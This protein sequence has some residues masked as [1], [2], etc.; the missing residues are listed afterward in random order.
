MKAT[1]PASQENADD[2]TCPPGSSRTW[3]LNKISCGLFCPLVTLGM[4]RGRGQ[5]AL[6]HWTSRK[7][8]PRKQSQERRDPA[9]SG[10]SALA[11]RGPAGT[12]G[13]ST[14]RESPRNADT[15][16][17][18]VGT[19]GT[20]PLVVGDR[21]VGPNPGNLHCSTHKTPGLP[22]QVAERG[23]AAE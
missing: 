10:A 3:Q 13:S 21:G 7:A 23:L 8:P 4:A 15:G 12:Y 5:L 2:L 20:W 22:V 11:L 1:C 18:A 16:Q 17:C 6:S 9:R 19:P 14:H